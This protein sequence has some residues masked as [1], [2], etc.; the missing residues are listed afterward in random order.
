MFFETPQVSYVA[1][2]RL[3]DTDVSA[4]TWCLVVSSLCV[5]LENCMLKRLPLPLCCQVGE[6]T[7]IMKAYINMIVKK[8]CS[9][10]SVSSYGSNWIR[11]SQ[12]TRLDEIAHGLQSLLSFR[13]LIRQHGPSRQKAGTFAHPVVNTSVAFLFA[14]S[15]PVTHP[16]EI[17]WSFLK[18]WLNCLISRKIS[19]CSLAFSFWTFCLV[20]RN[21][22]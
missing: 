7:K 12:E 6:I 13:T 10:K 1:T 2:E 4:F 3:I 19:S 14:I 8:R 22:H 9:V 15:K 11:W 21:K 17:Q 18:S 16:H 20:L 5:W